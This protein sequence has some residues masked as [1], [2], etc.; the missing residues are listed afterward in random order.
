MFQV[1]RD[2]F[3]PPQTLEVC[4]LVLQAPNLQKWPTGPQ[5]SLRVRNLSF[6][7]NSPHESAKQG[8]FNK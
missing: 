5:T 6:K 1:S 2:V 8:F 7:H 3:P 4:P